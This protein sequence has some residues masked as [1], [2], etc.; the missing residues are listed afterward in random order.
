[1]SFFSTVQVNIKE[2]M[3]ALLRA[4]R[5]ECGNILAES[6]I[7]TCEED[8]V[9]SGNITFN[10]IPSEGNVLI[11]KNGWWQA[12]TP[13]GGGSEFSGNVDI[14]GILNVGNIC[15]TA[16]NVGDGWIQ[17][18]QDVDGPTFGSTEGGQ[19]V[20]LSFDGKTLVMG[21]PYASPGGAGNMRVFDYND[22]TT[23]WVQRGSSISNPSLSLQAGWS[24]SISSDGNTVVM[25]IPQLSTGSTAVYT[26][27]GTSWIQ[28]GSLIP[29]TTTGDGNGISVSLSY[30]GSYL[31]IGAPY[32][33]TN[34]GYTR[35][36]EYSGTNW[37][38]RGS[39][40]FGS[41]TG[42]Q[43][44]S[45]VALTPDGNT[46]AVSSPLSNAGGTSRGLVRIFDW[47]GTDWTQRGSNINGT[48]DNSNSGST[49]DISHDGNTVVIGTPLINS[50]RG[51]VRVY[52][53]SGS[54]WV[55]R[56]SSINGTVNQEYAYVVSVSWDGNIIAIGS[57]AF[58][59]PSSPGL[60]RIYKWSDSINDWIQNGGDI[61]GEASSDT[62]GVGL[63]LSPDGSIVAIGAPKND[64]IA[65]DAG[66]VRVYTLA[67][68]SNPLNMCD[69][70]LVNVKSIQVT[71][72]I[73]IGNSETYTQS[74]SAIAIGGFSS[75]ISPNSVAI[76]TLS[77]TVL[78]NTVAIGHEITATETGGFFI[79]H[80][81]P[82]AY[83]TNS[84]GFLAGTNELVEVT[85]SRRFKENIRDL[86]S[87]SDV[88]DLF[89]PVRYIAKPGHGDNREHIGLIAEE[90]EEIFPEFITYDQEGQ[91]TG[92]LFDRIIAVTIKEL[93]EMSARQEEDKLALLSLEKDLDELF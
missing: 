71:E 24:V 15:T 67:L 55:Q 41:N 78:E 51:Q 60:V 22:T 54:A 13:T 83:T 85:S 26:W 33:S 52:I 45:Y 39:T 38:Q 9:L 79:R 11:F 32:N 93:K 64:S 56:G 73:V 46:I 1:M 44:G 48:V 66:H 50:A 61:V 14:G 75:A 74:S 27:T 88:F 8:I 34:T 62:S 77:S 87:V 43:C 37:V 70:N 6:S 89:R 29:G 82:G 68:G 92:V 40:I 84:A 58:G 47:S 16:L 91:V 76:G 3:S 42:D 21:A 81:G 69:S 20:D 19:S 28:Y 30:D 86:E 25:G 53:W 17:L 31:A 2:N 49:L 12:G 90:V 18:G 36:F 65:S 59:I 4:N 10:S 63:S 35:I 5:I 23:L 80:R 72:G 57:P 7:I